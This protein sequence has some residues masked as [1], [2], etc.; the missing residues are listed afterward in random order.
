MVSLEIF[1]G[2]VG[3]MYVC[4]CVCVCV[5]FIHLETEKIFKYA[6]AQTVIKSKMRNIFHGTIVDCQEAPP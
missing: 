6:F 2:M 1:L 3:N 4:V 5:C